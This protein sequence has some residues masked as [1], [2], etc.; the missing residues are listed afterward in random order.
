MRSSAFT[1]IE[2]LIVVAIIAIL[3]GIAVPNLLEA[4]TRA[5][6]SRV[7]A[8][9]RTIATGLEAY[10]VDENRYPPSTLI[11]LFR[12][13]VPLTTPIQYIVSVPLDVFQT[14]DTGA[15]PWRR[16][17]NYAYGAMPIANESRWA[18]ASDGP[19][20]RGNH[21]NIRFYPGHSPDIWENPDSGFD[22]V[23]Y[24]PTNGTISAGDIWRISDYNVE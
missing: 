1:L 22:F 14:Q 6:V 23:R 24:D 15:G 7:R 5:K 21:H 18:L 3:A 16:R 19:D 10:R 9:L 13:L 17:G 4:Q 20:L 12:R 8:D 2:L 11:P